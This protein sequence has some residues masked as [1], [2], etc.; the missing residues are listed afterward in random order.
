MKH[1]QCIVPHRTKHLPFCRRAHWNR[2][3]SNLFQTILFYWLTK[4]RATVIWANNQTYTIKAPIASGCLKKEKQGTLP[5]THPDTRE[6]NGCSLFGNLGRDF[7][8]CLS[9]P[10]IA[11]KSA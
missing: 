8:L 3:T 6:P 11:F 1:S 5:Q 2:C 9:K 4:K 10:H 7:L